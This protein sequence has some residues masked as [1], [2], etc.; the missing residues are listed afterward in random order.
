MLSSEQIL[1]LTEAAKRIA[2]IGGKS[3]HPSTL[4]RWGLKGVR[5]VKLE[6]LRIGGRI[7]T[8]MEAVERF[9]ERLAELPPPT[10]ERKALPKC[11]RTEKQRARAIAQSRDALK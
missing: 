4:W 3:P 7:V 5:G 8:S 9:S 1:T 2:P 11:R 6:I 10:R